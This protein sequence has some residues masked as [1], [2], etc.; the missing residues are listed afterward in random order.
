MKNKILHLIRDSAA[1][2]SGGEISR[3]LSIS[4]AAIWKH[5]EE[6]RKDGY[7]IK[8]TPRIGYHLES[9]PDKLIPLEI[10]NGLTTHVFG[11]QI[12]Y[13]ESVETTMDL[14]FKLALEGA[15]D[16]TLVCAETQTKGKGRMGRKWVSPAGKG[17][18]FS[19]IVRPSMHPSEVSR[20]TLMSAVAV[21]EAL[22][23]LS[24]VDVTIKW[25]NDLLVGNKKICGIL[26][27]LSAE[28]DQVK[29]VVIGIGINVNATAK[30]LPAVATSLRQE[31]GHP[32]LRVT[33]L[34]EVLKK[35]EEWYLKIAQ[36]GF[37]PMIARWKVYSSTLGRK[38][39][40][41]EINQLMTGTAI[42]LA[43][44]GALVIQDKKGVIYQK[45]SGDVE[46]C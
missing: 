23:D 32:Y 46:I 44:S 37:A 2:V 31:S 4:R 10:K 19:L 14:A 30:H 41:T 28:M 36:E 11:Q 3:K 20:L 40:F 6:L 29:F 25:P 8:A 42:D 5:I 43:P 34:Q 39:K 7:A 35:M 17:L 24:N 18:Y 12:V 38:V 26:T 21:C 45:I 22:R 1:S 16:G 27:E 13:M 15:K 9:C 33:V